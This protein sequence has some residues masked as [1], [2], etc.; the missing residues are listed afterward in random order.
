MDQN[1]SNHDIGLYLVR[2]DITKTILRSI[3]TLLCMF[4]TIAIFLQRFDS[5]S[6]V[7]AGFNLLFGFTGVVVI[8]TVIK[9]LDITRSINMPL[10][11]AFILSCINIIR[12]FISITKDARMDEKFIRS[13]IYCAFLFLSYIIFIWIFDLF[14][15]KLVQRHF[16]N[17]EEIGMLEDYAKALSIHDVKELDA[18]I[19]SKAKSNAIEDKWEWLSHGFPVDFL[20]E[21]KKDTLDDQY[22]EAL[23]MIVN[24]S[25]EAPDEEQADQK[26]QK[27]EGD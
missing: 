24:Y 1:S 18:F 12:A 25:N 17:P 15:L 13:S 11:C 14:M 3:M 23:N 8:F 9:L 10:V 19:T 20:T 21:H 5:K 7:T 27:G 6:I 22:L 26:D 16:S 2:R 4:V